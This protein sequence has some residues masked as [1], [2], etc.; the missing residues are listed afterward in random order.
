VFIGGVASKEGTS[1]VP[2]LPVPGAM[3][4]PGSP[5]TWASTVPAGPLSS[6]QWASVTPHG[7]SVLG[8]NGQ[9][10]VETATLDRLNN[11]WIG[12]RTRDT[13]GAVFRAVPAGPQGWVAVTKSGGVVFNDDEI[14]MLPT[15]DLGDRMTASIVAIGDSLV[16]WGGLHDTSEQDSAL[17]TGLFIR[18]D[19]VITPTTASAPEAQSQPPP[20][21]IAVDVDGDGRYDDLRVASVGPNST[22]R[23]TLAS[24]ETSELAFTTC[25]T[26][27]LGVGRLNGQPLIFYDECGATIINA[28][29]ATV[30]DGVLTRVAL[31]N[32]DGATDVVGWYAHSN[33]CPFATVDVVCAATDGHDTLVRTESRLVHKDG[34]DVTD[35]TEVD[36]TKSPAELATQFDRSWTKATYRLNRARLELVGTDMGTIAF[37]GPEPAGVPLRNRLQCGEVTQ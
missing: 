23:L 2:Q 25:G 21:E 13:P 32:A 22:L 29:L 3:F 15:T 33:C 26:R 27:L 11:G 37:D 10:K 31:D 30:A 8:T 36:Y 7:V 12:R 28:Q 16:I 4:T 6:P 24:G 18:L 5:G 1:A 20:D 17:D 14:R 35:P 9:S 19:D 34:T